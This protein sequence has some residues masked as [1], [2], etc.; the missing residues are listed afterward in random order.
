LERRKLA[1]VLF[2]DMSGSTAM[3]EGVDA[4]SV[5]DL[6][7]RYFHEMRSA[8]ERHGGTVEKFIGDAVMAVFGVPVAHEDDA[9][10]AA[11]AANEMRLRLA[12]LNDELERRFG[13]RIA[14]RIGIESGEVV[15]GESTKRHAIVTGDTVNVAARLEQAASPGEILLGERTYRLVRDAVAAEPVAPLSLKGKA[16]LVSAYRLLG[17]GDSPRGYASRFE[18]RLV[19]R[20]AELDLLRRE[21]AKAVATQSCRRVTV[22]GHPVLA[23][24]ASAPSSSIWSAA[25]R[26]CCRVAA[27][28]MARG[29]RTGRSARSSARLRPSTT[30]TRRR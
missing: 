23:S 30:R 21:F 27:S 2:C 28:R 18:A 16:E 14:L 26:R 25:R 20:A 6:M 7:F 11:R 9:L 1:S 10:R 24:R 3:G 29:S 5:R 13:T 22:V 12:S 4:E 15:A 19:G 8:I 17:V